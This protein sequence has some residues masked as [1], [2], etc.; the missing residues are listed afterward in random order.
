[1][2]DLKEKIEEIVNKVKGDENILNNFKEN[3]VK[4]VEQLLNIDLPDKQID[5]IVEA[6]KA[7]INLDEAGSILGKIKN[8]F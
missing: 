3:P 8:M 1:M 4:T 6:V 7:K 2:E 5:N